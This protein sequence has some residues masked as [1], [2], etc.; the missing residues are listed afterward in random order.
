MSAYEV[1]G[2]DEVT[3]PWWEATGSHRLLVQRCE[4]GHHQHPPR[5]LCTACGDM[6]RLGWVDATGKAV[7]DVATTVYRSPLPG[8]DAPYVVARVVLE[9]GPIL[10]TN[11]IDV[12]PS[13]EVPIGS[14]L[15]LDWRDLPDGR[16]LPVFRP[17]PTPASPGD[18]GAD[19]TGRTSPRDTTNPSTGASPVAT[20][21]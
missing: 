1:P 18:L 10:L 20:Q 19:R 9:E 16:A 12:D 15:E 11:I 13:V 21:E 3:G 2:A 4:C 17:A 8:L 7:V 14:V 5:A 6:D